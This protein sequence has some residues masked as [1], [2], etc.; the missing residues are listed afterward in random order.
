MK[1]VDI[2]ISPYFWYDKK[3]LL[4]LKK[5][6]NCSS[7]YKSVVKLINNRIKMLENILDA[8]LLTEK[9]NEYGLNENISKLSLKDLINLTKTNLK[10]EYKKI[11]AVI[12]VLN[13]E[14]CINRC[15]DSIINKVDEII[16]LD[17]GSTD[18]TI[19]YIKKYDTSIIKL[20]KYTWNYSF[21]DARNFAKSKATTDW[22]FFIDAD[23]YLDTSV[24]LTLLLNS[25]NN[26]PIINSLVISPRIVNHNDNSTISVGRIFLRESGI[27]FF[28]KVHEELR[29]SIYDRG[30]DLINISM[31]ILIK[32]DG[33]TL[34]II[35]DKKKIKRNIDLLEEM[36]LIEPDNPRWAYFLVRDGIDVLEINRV[37]NIIYDYVLLDIKNEMN[38]KNLKY[39]D[40][41]FAFLNI[42]ATIK[43]SNKDFYALDKI[44]DILDHLSPQNSNSFY[45]STISK[46]IRLKDA[47]Q[48][49]LNETIDY[50]SN[51]MDIQYGMLHSNGYHIDF[52]IA[53]LLLETGKY[54][55]SFKYFSFLEDKF[56]D[57]GI[58][59]NYKEIFSL[60]DFIK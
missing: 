58:I 43:L 51:H 57:L 26:I 38:I 12:I 47:M 19:D 15:I 56:I 40:F 36:L 52:L 6:L 41:T 35:K 46:F 44:I 28:G 1:K 39:H 53:L 54:L 23:E 7:E 27:N 31:D 33:Y 2:K 22:I 49:L 45:Y 59:K 16:I 11:G 20:Y 14:R 8:Q 30:N 10:I 60:K 48:L 4:Y 9:A 25:I 21:S 3:N 32:H 24:D 55:S 34:D 50:R 13:E 29:K 5:V 18:N 17:T 42:L 37:E